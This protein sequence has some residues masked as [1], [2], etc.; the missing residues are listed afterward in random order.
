[1]T[2]LTPTG[3][4]IHENGRFF[5]YLN[6]SCVMCARDFSDIIKRVNAECM[7]FNPS[8]RCRTVELYYQ[9]TKEEFSDLEKDRISLY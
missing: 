5:L 8:E 1:M 2:L 3:R 7:S 9:G 4:I 6:E